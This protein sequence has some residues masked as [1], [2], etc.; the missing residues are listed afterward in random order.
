MS[1]EKNTTNMRKLTLRIGFTAILIAVGVILSYIN[2]F[3]YFTISGTKINPFAHLIN[4]ISGVLLGIS[5]SVI[6]ASSI[7][8]IRYSTGIGSIHAFHGGI[9]GA[10]IVSIISHFLYKKYPR[11]VEYATFFEPFGTVF[12]GGTITSIIEGFTIGNLLFYWGIFMAS[13]VIGSSLG[14]I[15]LKII[16]DSGYSRETFLD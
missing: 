12:I 7:A 1:E 15:M 14:F 13:S 2:P 10:I 3:G 6:A 11:Y 5:F 16:K 9:S 4:A 8:V